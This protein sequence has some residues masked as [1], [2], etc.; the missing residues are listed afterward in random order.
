[1][2]FGNGIAITDL[3]NIDTWHELQ[4]LFS[5]V[6][7]LSLCTVS[8]KGEPICPPSRPA[9][10]CKDILPDIQGHGN[11][12][13]VCPVSGHS[14]LPAEAERGET[15]NMKCPFDLDVFIVPI[16]A[17]GK[18]IAAFIIMGP[19]IMNSRRSMSEYAAY[20]KKYGVSLEALTDTLIEI[21]VFTHSRLYSF[22][23]LI[24]SVFSQMA[25]AGYH[26][27][28]LGEIAPE[29]V[30]MDPVFSRYYEEK[31]LNALLNSCT[32]A[33]DAD[34]GSVMTLDKKSKSLHVKVSSR[35]GDDAANNA[36]MKVGEGIAGFA[37]ATA[38][39]II[40]PKDGNKG[41]LA[42]K[43]KRHYI[44]S[45]MIIPFND[46]KSEDVYGVINLNIVRK[47]RD[48]SDR[49]IAI[50]KELINLASTALIPLQTAQ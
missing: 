38:K 33:L 9:R 24:E 15:I 12:C 34:S 49:D 30:H 16:K 43:L 10:F 27:R 40:L 1:M 11:L 13:K 46:G 14:E 19:V 31:V 39:P 18:K 32:L 22:T 4:D 28:R 44:K 50:V 36:Y 41:E 5:D 37:A 25:Q 3:V 6:F 7:E 45:S 26:K 47:D 42:G 35:L 17:V 8:L 29:L 2:I 23:T 48:F 21:S 20:A